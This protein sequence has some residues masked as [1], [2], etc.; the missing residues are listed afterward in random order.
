MSK[1]NKNQVET[2]ENPIVET[3]EN[4]DVVPEQK[5]ETKKM[6]KKKLAGIVTGVTGVLALGAYGIGKLVKKIHSTEDPMDGIADL[7]D[8]DDDD[9]VEEVKTE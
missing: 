3:N 5:E 4:Q 9:L 2:T 6:D 7:M 8:D 1:K